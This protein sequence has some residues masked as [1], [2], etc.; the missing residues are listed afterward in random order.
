VKV[1]D[2]RRWNENAEPLHARQQAVDDP[3]HRLP[4]RF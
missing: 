1:A 4:Q 3:G 2:I